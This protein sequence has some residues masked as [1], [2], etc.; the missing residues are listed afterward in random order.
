MKTASD[1][2]AVAALTTVKSSMVRSKADRGL[3]QQVMHECDAMARY[4]LSN[5]LPVTPTIVDDLYQIA[6]TGHQHQDDD[7][8]HTRRLVEVHQALAKLI[9]P[10]TPR[11]ITLLDDEHRAHTWLYFLGPTKLI[12][13]LSLTALGFL[14]ALITISLHVRVNS[15]NINLGLL[16]S[17]DMTLF[18]NQLF[19]LCCA[20]LGA[21]FSGLFLANGFIAKATYDPRYDSSYWSRIILGLISG[22]IIVELLPVSLFESGTMHSFGKPTLSMLGGF[23]A[24]V[25]YRILQRLVDTLGS[26]VKAD[27]RE[28]IEQQ[29]ATLQSREAE[30]RS[31]VSAETASK[32]MALSQEIGSLEGKDAAQKVSEMAQALL[33][34]TAS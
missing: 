9:F 12:R 25:V 17:N 4:A 14:V 31:K 27:D 11:A 19:L 29:Q 18:L 2:A 24:T 34:K 32:L 6:K 21:T 10:A 33:P 22:L 15:T 3:L 30:Q 1:G 28:V 16:N 7:N 13:Q 20:G 5:G 8:N 26:L 23:S